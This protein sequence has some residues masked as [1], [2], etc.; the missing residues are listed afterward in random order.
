M[1]KDEYFTGT[2]PRFTVGW[3]GALTHGFA[4]YSK[5]CIKSGEF[6]SGWTSQSYMFNITGICLT[7][8]LYYNFLTKSFLDTCNFT[9]TLENRGIPF[10]IF[11]YL[12]LNLSTPEKDCIPQ[13]VL[14]SH[15]KSDQKTK[16]KS[17]TDQILLQNYF[18]KVLERKLIAPSH[19]M[20]LPH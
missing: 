1:P 4:R 14:R 11:D 3:R 2:D 6:W 13:N 17:L 9:M 15:E 12:P 18:K 20:Y 7:I 19:Q 5:S 10:L 16:K 8:I